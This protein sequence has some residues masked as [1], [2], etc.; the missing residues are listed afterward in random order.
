MYKISELTEQ[1]KKKVVSAADAVS[2]IKSGD[3][4]HYGLFGGMVRDL[5]DALAQRAEQLEDVFVYGT[6]WGNSEPPSIL[7]RD[8]EARH[9]KYMNTHFSPIGPPDEQRWLLL[10]H[11]GYV[12]Q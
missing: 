2:I 3:R 5:D 4:V 7:K 1:Y 9:F 8:P 12:P 11:T 10:V 6:I